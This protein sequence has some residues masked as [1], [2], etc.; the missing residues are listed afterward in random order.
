M[1]TAKLSATALKVDSD[2]CY[3]AKCNIRSEYVT[4][5]RVLE[6]VYHA[7]YERLFPHTDCTNARFVTGITPRNTGQYPP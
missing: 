3:E 6:F 4:S 2:R 5:H 7:R 1:Q